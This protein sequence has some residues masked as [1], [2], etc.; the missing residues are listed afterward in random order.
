MENYIH[1]KIFILWTFVIS[2]LV[3]EWPKVLSPSPNPAQMR[4][5]FPV[6]NANKLDLTPALYFW[7]I[8]HNDWSRWFA[9][10]SSH[11]YAAPI[12]V[13]LVGLPTKKKAKLRHLIL[14]SRV[15][16]WAPVEMLLAKL[17][18]SVQ[19][20]S[21]FSIF[22][23]WTLI[24]FLKSWRIIMIGPGGLLLVVP[25]RFAVPVS[26]LWVGLQKST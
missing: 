10:S 20:Y 26:V 1:M 6:G 22:R 19:Q 4:S 13:L 21:V 23:C 24:Y 2:T 25:H 12:T 3:N 15:T 11:I 8:D 18:E 9:I 14:L 17:T 5:L 16:Y 7:L